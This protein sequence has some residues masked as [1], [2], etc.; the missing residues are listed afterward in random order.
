MANSEHARPASAMTRRNVSTLDASF[1][2]R[3]LSDRLEMG[4]E[5][6]LAEMGHPWVRA[7]GGPFFLRWSFY[8]SKEIRRPRLRDERVTTF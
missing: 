6:I 1:R 2:D 8:E 7:W 4:E 3:P 5:A